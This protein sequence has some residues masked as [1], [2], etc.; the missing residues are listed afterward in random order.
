MRRPGILI[1]LIALAV[2]GGILILT[3]GD[4][5]PGPPLESTVTAEG[6]A[7]EIPEGWV[8]EGTFRWDYHPPGGADGFD[9]WSVARACPTSGCAPAS[10]EEW[11]ALADDLP[12]FVDMREAVGD[13]LFDL[14]EER[15]SD[16]HV[17]RATTAAVGRIVFVA[18]F[19]DGAED[20]VACSARVA[21]GSDERLADEIVRVCRATAARR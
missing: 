6:L 7:T 15:L 4:D 10:L 3:A 18:A 9:V 13:T 8:A 21:L 1:G 16:A 5:D 17:A 20:Y 19:A 12:T 11:L 14:T 2:I